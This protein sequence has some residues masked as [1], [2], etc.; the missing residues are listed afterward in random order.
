ML[1]LLCLSVF[2][3]LIVALEVIVIYKDIPVFRAAFQR[4]EDEYVFFLACIFGKS[5]ND[6]SCDPLFNNTCA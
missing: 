1:Y 4:S 6:Q 5:V 2:T 3:E